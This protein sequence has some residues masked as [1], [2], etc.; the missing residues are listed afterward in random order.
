MLLM[1][2]ARER[3]IKGKW[4]WTKKKKKTEKIQN[5]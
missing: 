4:N 5:N 2:L 3:K 1:D